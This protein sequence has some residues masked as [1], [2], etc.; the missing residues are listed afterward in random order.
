[1]YAKTYWIIYDGYIYIYILD[2]SGRA[3]RGLNSNMHFYNEHLFAIVCTEI[4]G[5][6]I[7]FSCGSDG[8][9]VSTGRLSEHMIR[10]IGTFT[11]L[12]K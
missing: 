7:N 12:K 3:S 4:F 2:F 8:M 10:D 9:G 1:M 11:N 6:E 5:I